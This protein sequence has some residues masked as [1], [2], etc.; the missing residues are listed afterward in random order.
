MENFTVK[1]CNRN[2]KKF[3]LNRYVKQLVKYQDTA[4]WLKNDLTKQQFSEW[5]LSQIQNRL[6]NISIQ[7]EG[8]N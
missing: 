6:A 7:I 5:I 3:N 1:L 2:G 4:Y 8:K